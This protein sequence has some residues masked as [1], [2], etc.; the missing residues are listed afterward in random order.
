MDRLKQ[1]AKHCK[2]SK[3]WLKDGD[4]H[5]PS[6]R[7]WKSRGTAHIKAEDYGKV[8]DLAPITNKYV[9]KL[10]QEL[11][12][13][14]RAVKRSENNRIKQEIEQILLEDAE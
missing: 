8:F 4:W 7:R 3:V 10:K 5:T 9:K 11:K 12:V 2:I 13:E 6:Q 14:Y 1:I